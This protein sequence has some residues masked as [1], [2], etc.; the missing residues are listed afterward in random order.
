[1]SVFALV[2]SVA[3]LPTDTTTLIERIHRF[4]P[5]SGGYL[6]S[7]QLWFGP[8]G[9]RLREEVTDPAGS[10]ELTFLPLHDSE[11]GE[12][13]AVYLEGESEGPTPEAYSYSPDGMTKTVVYFY[14]PGVAS[15]RNVISLDGT[16]R[17]VSKRYFRA[18]GT[19]YGEEDVLWDE[20]GNQL[21][22]DFRYT[23]RAGGASFRYEYEAFDEAGRWTRRTMLR[24]GVPIRMEV[25]SLVTSGLEPGLAATAPFLPGIVSTEAS[26]TSPS[27]SADGKRLVFARYGDDWS[28]KDPYFG[29]LTEEGWTVEPLPGIGPV[30][31]L[32]ISPDGE[33]LIIS[34]KSEEGSRELFGTRRSGEGWSPRENLT[35]EYGIVGTYPALT[36][37]GDLLVYDAEGTEGPGVYV[38]RK[39]DSGFGPAEP[40]YVPAGGTTFDAFLDES[41][42][43]LLVS[44]CLDDTC[45]SEGPNGIWEVRVKKGVA[46]RAGKIQGLPY[47]WGVQPVESLGLLVFTDGED[48]LSA[49]L[50]EANRGQPS[51]RVFFLSGG[52]DFL[53]GSWEGTLEYLDYSDDK[54]LVRLPT[55]LRCDRSEAG[56]GL[57]LRF[58]YEEPD[59]R[60]VFSGERLFETDD[61]VF[62]GGLW[63]IVEWVE[64]PATGT[65]RLE[66]SQE[67]EDNGRQA[68]I[69]TSVSLQGDDLTITKSVR[70]TGS[71]EELQRHQYRLTRVD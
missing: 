18:D 60:T 49:P 24:D 32:A 2:L 46:G 10:L 38:A 70:Y 48:I 55:G 67:G 23:D 50:S 41:S 8:E 37:S 53:L 63:H 69:R 59:G 47:A 57:N 16:G 12:S 58:S 27:F 71:N 1:M 35:A 68:R 44:R 54:T 7:Q 65:Y 9:R 26:E 30:Y 6:G 5:V 28:Q 51:N 17:E 15:D 43:T 13:G 33:T 29:L 11:G 25:R 22:W 3:V 52:F 64:D 36:T 45:A 56:Q 19:Q 39:Q 4:D 31:N 21:G 42:G 40:L 20:R 61:G 62:F 14:P 66:L 34:T